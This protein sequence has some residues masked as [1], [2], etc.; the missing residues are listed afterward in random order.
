MFKSK[1]YRKKLWTGYDYDL[2]HKAEKEGF[3]EP[4]EAALIRMDTHGAGGFQWCGD[5]DVA[6]SMLNLGWIEWLTPL[7]QNSIATPA[8]MKITDNGYQARKR[9]FEKMRSL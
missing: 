7:S 1:N 4:H 2:V 5:N 6:Q 8:A 3:V 9:L